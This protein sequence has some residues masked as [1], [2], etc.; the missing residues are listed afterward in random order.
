MQTQTIDSV[1]L[2]AKA[3]T[4]IR[5]HEDFIHGMAVNSVE[6]KNG[7]LIFKGDY[8]L[9]DQGLPT[10]KSTAACSMVKHLTHVLSEKYQLID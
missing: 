7:V 6:Q 3:N 9:D 1:S 8:F 10:P 4:I 5:D 2:L